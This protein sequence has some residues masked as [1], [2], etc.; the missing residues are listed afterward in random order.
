MTLQSFIEQFDYEQSV[1]LLEGKRDVLDEDKI[2]LYQLGQLLATQTKHLIFRSGNAAGSDQFFSEG[3]AY[4]DHTRLEVIT[5]YSGHRDNTNKAY[6]TH[7]LDQIDI[8]SQPDIL[9]HSKSNKKME[10]L[11]NQYASG[12]RN[13]YTIKAAYILR[14]TVKVVGSDKIKP[15]SFGIFY[16][17]LSNP[18]SGGT[19]HTMKVCRANNIPIITQTVWFEWLKETW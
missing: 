16:D 17:D 1:V 2:K 19:G 3:V 15:A 4:V 14:D 7:S 6:Q 12:I 13:Q 9:Y 18:E 8:A 10:S 5:P 11:I